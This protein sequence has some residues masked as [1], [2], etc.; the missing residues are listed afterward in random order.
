MR[1]KGHGFTLIE[2]LIVVAI[3]A[4]LAAIAVPNF[5]EA[6]IRS[7]VSRAKAD[8]RSIATALESY[9]VSYNKYP[10]NP[11]T[12]KGFNVTPWQLTTPEAYI[13]SRP[14]DP[15]KDGKDVT[16]T[17]NPALR[18]ERYYYD[19]FGIISVDE[20][21]KFYDA[22]INI[23]PLAVNDDGS[24]SGANRNAFEKYGRWVQWSVGPDGQYWVES[25]DFYG[26]G[27]LQNPKYVPW[28]FSFDVPYDPT[29]GTVS[30]GNVIRSQVKSDGLKPYFK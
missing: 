3:I 28:G 10:P 7:K 13:T 8:L 27:I 9:L 1:L 25:D 2:L 29:N 6:Q 11:D 20:Y 21:I 15:F 16:Q 24:F 5:L 18:H 26:G 12:A 17:T 14:K 30:F 22:G 4:V 23:F 19:Y